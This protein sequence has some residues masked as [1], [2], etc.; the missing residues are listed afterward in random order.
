MNRKRKAEEVFIDLT[1]ETKR[2]KS[3]NKY[4]MAQSIEIINNICN[5]IQENYIYDPQSDVLRTVELFRSAA[6]E[7]INLGGDIIEFCQIV[8][9][10]CRKIIQERENN[11]GPIGMTGPR[12]GL[13]DSDY[14]KISYSNTNSDMEF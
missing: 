10:K 11:S 3:D 14:E 1:E 13:V 4:D 9:D 8:A 5:K 2:I 12:S 7:H 6:T